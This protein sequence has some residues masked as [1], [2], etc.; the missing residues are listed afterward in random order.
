M[1]AISLYIALIVAVQIGFGVALLRICRIECATI[2]SCF[3]AYWLGFAMTVAFLQIWHLFLPLNGTALLVVILGGLAALFFSR[4]SLRRLFTLVNRRQLIVGSLLCIAASAWVSNNAAGLPNAFDSGVYHVPTVQ[5]YTHYPAVFGLGNLHDR[6]AFNSSA[7]LY[8]AMLD[9]GWWA[10]RATHVANASLVLVLLLQVLSSIV[11]LFRDEAD[12]ASR[13]FDLCLVLPVTAIVISHDI[14][15]FTTDIPPAVVLFVLCSSVFRLVAGKPNTA[16][17]RADWLAAMILAPLTVCLKASY[18]VIG[19]SLVAV[20]LGF[21]ASAGLSKQFV[22]A[23]KWGVLAALVLLVPWA[24]HGVV[25]SGYPVYPASIG[26]LPVAWKVP[27]ELAHATESW[28]LASAKHS[29]QGGLSW[30]PEWAETQIRPLSFARAPLMSRGLL[31]ILFPLALAAASFL[32]ILFLKLRKRWPDQ[33]GKPMLFIAACTVGAVFWFLTAPTARFGFPI[34]WSL[35]AATVAV[36][37]QQNERLARRLALPVAAVLVLITI[38]VPLPPNHSFK[39]IVS[40]LAGRPGPDHG[41]H[42]YPKVPV[43]QFVTDS[44]LELNVPDQDDRCLDSPLPCTPHPAPDLIRT[45]GFDGRPAFIT[46][47]S[48][49]QRNWPIVGPNDIKEEFLKTLRDS[50]RQ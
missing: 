35:A 6:L 24:L 46:N 12:P 4:Q 36:L 27:V 13:A 21:Y 49:Q 3:T 5:W 42:P 9:N 7:L 47:G 48:W 17:S 39:A 22:R 14:S 25:L 1:L 40:R 41:L 2:D 31:A 34:M 28:V 19:P 23:L 44:G 50:G 26:G 11:R 29:V 32:G 8:D 45:T 18:L 43:T 20:T 16:E 38:L 37:A 10:G 30:L 33:N 15:S